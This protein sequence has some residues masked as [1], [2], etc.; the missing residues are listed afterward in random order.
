MN[1][2]AKNKGF[3]LIELMLAM[4]F[5][6]ILL[7]AI[8]MTIIQIS[9]IYNRGI[10]LKEV[11][12]V[13]RTLSDELDRGISESQ[14]FLLTPAAHRYVTTTWGG[15]VCLGQYSYIWNY[16]SALQLG[17]TSTRNVYS[18]ETPT[19]TADSIKFVKVPDNG[20]NYCSGNSLYDKIDQTNAVELLQAGDHDLAL[21]QLS[22]TSLDK[23]AD[24]RT[25]QRLYTVTMI[26][27]T[28]KV[29]ALTP[30]ATA[31]LGP[32]DKNSDLQYC[33][34]QQFTLVV[35]SQNNVN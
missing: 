14:T 34:I 22:I 13:A 2:V 20:G 27:G 33:S 8:A 30:D 12:Q 7:L 6:S 10:T 5:I 18:S 32:S 29:S 26:V 31:C 16:G 15:R 3:T 23:A 4:T 1:H 11:N 17:A 35:R 21:H 28:N 9:T 24:S 19:V 25:G